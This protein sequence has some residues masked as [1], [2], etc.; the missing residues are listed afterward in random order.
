MAARPVPARSGAGGI[1]RSARAGR[2]P[3]E[4]GNG[5]TAYWVCSMMRISSA[6]NAGF[7]VVATCRSQAR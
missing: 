4:K 6:S 7:I 5:R 1:A 3:V 2:V